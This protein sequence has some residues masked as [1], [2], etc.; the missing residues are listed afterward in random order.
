[1]N[2][3]YV[4]VCMKPWEED[5]A[6]MLNRCILGNCCVYVMVLFWREI[7]HLN[8][9]H[10]TGSKVFINSYGVNTISML[11]HTGELLLHSQKCMIKPCECSL[12]DRFFMKPWGEDTASMLNKYIL[13]NYCVYVMVSFWR[14]IDHLNAVHVTGFSKSV[15]L[16]PFK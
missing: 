9:V 2:A 1:M 7:D 5:T 6:S 11:I 8:A 14:E 15:R 12:C 3:G 16:E 10:V 13:G 4:T